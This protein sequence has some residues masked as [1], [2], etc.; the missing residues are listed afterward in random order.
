MAKKAHRISFD[1]DTFETD[2]V[3]ELLPVQNN[4]YTKRVSRI[5]RTMRFPIPTLI[6]EE[7][8]LN[9]GDICY[10]IRYSEGYYIAFITR[11]DGV[12]DKNIRSR[13]LIK[14]GMYNTLFVAIPQFIQQDF[15]E[16]I[17]SVQLIRP[18][19]FK[20]HEWQIRFLTDCI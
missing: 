13:K 8:N 20:L 6:C 11:P 3:N 17:Q 18:K 9:A 7:L 5:A 15:K 14:A 2:I 4:F 10:F 19:G 1:M 16:P 12:N